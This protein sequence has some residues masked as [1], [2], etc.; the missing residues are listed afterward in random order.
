MTR[1]A[2][3]ARAEPKVPRFRVRDEIGLRVLAR[4]DRSNES[5]EAKP[6][7]DGPIGANDRR[8]GGMIAVWTI[9]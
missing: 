2:I 9:R 8:R 5:R 3:A 6:S 7:R 1:S 4:A